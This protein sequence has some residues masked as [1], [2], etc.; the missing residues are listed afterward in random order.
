MTHIK[1]CVEEVVA[2]N[3][4]VL[5]SHKA[6]GRER[7]EVVRYHILSTGE[8]HS[9]NAWYREMLTAWRCIVKALEDKED[10]PA[11]T[12]LKLC[13]LVDEGCK[14]TVLTHPAELARL[15]TK[16][17]SLTSGL[18]VKELGMQTLL[19]LAQNASGFLKISNEC[20][21]RGIRLRCSAAT[22]SGSTGG[23]H[24]FPGSGSK[25]VS[26]FDSTTEQDASDR[27]F[28]L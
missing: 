7:D 16:N 14:V 15:Q 12:F 26:S 9:A 17:S 5:E 11:E 10:K 24:C 23:S 18:D 27:A 3:T 19:A 20:A 8:H 22:L 1:E 6:F 21:Y 25:R 28:L 4:T 13:G 2:R